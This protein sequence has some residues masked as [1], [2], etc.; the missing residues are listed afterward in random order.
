MRLY[1]VRSSL[2]GVAA[3]DL[4]AAADRAAEAAQR[5]SRE[6][7]RI[8]YLESTHVAADGWFGSLYET[9]GVRDVRLATERAA[10]PFDDIVEATRYANGSEPHLGGSVQFSGQPH[11]PSPRPGSESRWR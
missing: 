9:D 11:P 10:I 1:L 2:L 6:G 5:M 8:H 4:R 3:A 7:F